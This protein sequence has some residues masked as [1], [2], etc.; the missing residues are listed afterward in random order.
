M[1]FSQLVYSL[2]GLG[3]IYPT[4]APNTLWYMDMIVLFYIITPLL[5]SSSLLKRIS[6]AIIVFIMAGLCLKLSGGAIFDGRFFWYFP[7]FIL[8]LFCPT[9]IL[10]HFL[11]ISTSPSKL[12]RCNILKLICHISSCLFIPS[13][14]CVCFPSMDGYPFTDYS[15]FSVYLL[16]STICTV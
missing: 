6:K 2:F 1:T 4:P 5:L 9:I 11:S 13:P 8:G 10:D 15:I 12:G 7:T 14:I 3:I 16:I